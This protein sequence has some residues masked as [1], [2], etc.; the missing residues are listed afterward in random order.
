VK[1]FYRG[2][3]PPGISRFIIPIGVGIGLIA[4]ILKKIPGEK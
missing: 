4:D 3:R 2:Y 1:Q